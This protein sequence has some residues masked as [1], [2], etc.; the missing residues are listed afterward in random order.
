MKTGREAPVTLLDNTTD[1]KITPQLPEQYVLTG[2][3]D[4]LKSM[5]VSLVLQKYG[6]KKGKSLRSSEKMNDEIGTL[7]HELSKLKKSLTP[8]QRNSQHKTCSIDVQAIYEPVP[9]TE[10]KENAGLTVMGPD[11]TQDTQ[12]G[13]R[14]YRLR[15]LEFRRLAALNDITASLPTP[16]L[17]FSNSNGIAYDQYLGDIT[18][19]YTGDALS[20]SYMKRNVNFMY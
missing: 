11:S 10:M 12:P 13:S 18:L 20:P 7:V 9:D 2:N 16:L 19:D 8:Q 1:Q 14:T 17:N 6:V 4:N 15:K 5:P 3:I